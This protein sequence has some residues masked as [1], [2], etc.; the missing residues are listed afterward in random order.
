MLAVS[1][2]NHEVFL[3]FLALYC[4][5]FGPSGLYHR[6]LLQGRNWKENDLFCFRTVH[7]ASE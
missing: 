6:G 3:T 1:D 7:D 4:I 5:N 2:G